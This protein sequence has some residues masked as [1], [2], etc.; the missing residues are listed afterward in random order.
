MSLKRPSFNLYMFTH[1]LSEHFLTKECD[2]KLKKFTKIKASIGELQVLDT[3]NR[4][5]GRFFSR[6]S[7]AYYGKDSIDIQGFFNS[8]YF[9]IQVRFRVEKLGFNEITVFQE[10]IKSFKNAT[11]IIFCPG[12]LKP[13]CVQKTSLFKD[14]LFAE[15]LDELTTKVQELSS[16]HKSQRIKF[17]RPS[18]KLDD[19]N[20]IRRVLDV[21]KQQKVKLHSIRYSY[22]FPFDLEDNVSNIGYPGFDYIGTFELKDTTHHVVVRNER[23]ASRSILE[24]KLEEFK[25]AKKCYLPEYYFGVFIINSCSNDVLPKLIRDS[26]I[27]VSSLNDVRSNLYCLFK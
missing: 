6:F 17:E 12:G 13:S 25:K 26:N 19:P 8:T 11:G 27:I 9:I 21:L 4:L 7:I 2:E 3:L 14:I 16:G 20:S 5:G 15:S 1:N 10:K 23:G 22:H 24:E 18:W